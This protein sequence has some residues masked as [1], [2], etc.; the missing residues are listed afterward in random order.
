MIVLSTTA[1]SEPGDLFAG[2]DPDEL[3][4]MDGFDGCI[5]GVVERFGQPPIV[6]YNKQKVLEKL[7][8]DGGTWED[9]EE[10]FEFNQLG[11]WVGESTP[12]FLS[13]NSR[14]FA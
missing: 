10:F 9:A 14:A 2:F 11:A 5:V 12:C 1:G 13:P 7:M 3:L 8:E 6:C 4:V